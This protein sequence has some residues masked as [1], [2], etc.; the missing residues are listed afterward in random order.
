[1][2][3]VVVT[4]V[5]V[6]TRVVGTTVMGRMARVAPLGLGSDGSKHQ[7]DTENQHGQ[8]SDPLKAFHDLILHLPFFSFSAGHTSAPYDLGSGEPA[9]MLQR[10]SESLFSGQK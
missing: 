7:S 8:D 5:V 6:V 9:R 10:N 4:A 1:V 3:I 2:A